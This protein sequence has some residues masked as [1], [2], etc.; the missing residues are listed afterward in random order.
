MSF[1]SATIVK[2]IVLETKTGKTNYVNISDVSKSSDYL[3][4]KTA[5][6][7]SDSSRSLD[8]FQ[9]AIAIHEIIRDTS[10]NLDSI[11][12]SIQMNWIKDSGRS[13]DLLSRS[14]L[15]PLS[16]SFKSLDRISSAKAFRIAIK[17]IL[18]GGSSIYALRGKA[19]SDTVK[20]IDALNKLAKRNFS[21]SSKAA[22]VF[23]RVASFY[24]AL[25]DSSKSADSIARKVAFIRAAQ[26]LSKALEQLSRTASFKRS[27]T[28]TSK[29]LDNLSKY[30][31]RIRSL[32]DISYTKEQ[33][34]KVFSAKRSLS[35]TS[36]TLD[37]LTK[38]IAVKRSLSDISYTKE[39]FSKY[40]SIVRS[41]KDA[42]IAKEAFLRTI[43]LHLSL[44]DASIA[45]ENFVKASAFVRSMK[46]TILSDSYSIKSRAM[47]LAD[48]A[49]A[50]E[51]VLK[52]A[53]KMIQ[54]ASK[55]L[56]N[57]SKYIARI[58][59]LSDISY[60]KEQFSK[61]SSI[62]KNISDAS[63]VKE[64]FLRTITS[65]LSLHDT[66][67]AKEV[68][69]RTITS[70]LSLHDTSIA[71]ENFAKASV[72]V[73]SM[74][75]T[76]LSD[77][78]SI[79]LGTKNL[80]DYAKANENVLR[81]AA[82][83]IQD[84]VF[85]KEAFASF[86][87]KMVSLN[88]KIVISDS[89]YQ[90]IRRIVS[91]KESAVAKESFFKQ[92]YLFKEDSV[93]AFDIAYRNVGKYISDYLRALESIQALKT[94]LITLRDTIS[95][96]FSVYLTNIKNI[97]DSAT[98]IDI[99]KRNIA[100]EIE[101][102]ISIS[103]SVQALKTALVILKDQLIGVF[104]T[105]K[106]FSFSVADQ[107]TAEDVAAKIAYTLTGIEVRRVYT[108]PQEKIALADRVLSSD[109]NTRVDACKNLL[110]IFKRVRDKLGS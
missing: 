29:S 66:S 39:Q 80:A 38:Y 36:K 85:S 101:E 33:F 86:K 53:S 104:D 105:S 31:A 100:K 43:A 108:F 18:P 91:I 102:N 67:I 6:S 73:R 75:D 74:K 28:D 110:E 26:D 99:A 103:D 81:Q 10:R 3:N 94:L 68:F 93:S 76:V 48:Y 19:L 4:R 65:Y 40:S 12:K 82:K 44:Q 97:N 25:S 32:S 57:F 41:I 11:A 83:M 87:S 13:L 107:A 51:N 55:S 50:N 109:H 64:S 2:I 37:Q 59:S 15:R 21:D 60:A 16:D 89:I 27:M 56:D 70:H 1:T 5:K 24:R 77:Y 88:E 92:I 106:S 7:L 78:S 14:P 58:R 84:T 20:S 98:V 71:K 72:F 49:K 95:G 34:S 45:K 23:G 90:L 69:S 35:D 8:S 22:D 30:I 46:D 54:D 47:N 52:Q 62:V 9:R 63:I 42:S 17:D 96:D 61:Y 79:K